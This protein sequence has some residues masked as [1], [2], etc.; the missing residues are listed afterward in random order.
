MYK[1]L[2]SNLLTTLLLIIHFS[3]EKKKIHCVC[4]YSKLLLVV[5]HSVCLLSSNVKVANILLFRRNIDYDFQTNPNYVITKNVRGWSG[6]AMVLCKL[7]V[8]GRPTCLDKSM[9]RA[10]CSCSRSGWGFFWTFL[11]S[12]ILSLLFFP[13]FGRR[14]D[15]D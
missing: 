4:F 5:R 9:A 10:Y 1:T 11:L 7:P 6:G 15:I 3:R 2:E 12:S 8:R 13:L 14:P